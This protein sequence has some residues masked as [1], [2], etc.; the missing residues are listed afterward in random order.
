MA[1]NGHD[2]APLPAPFAEALTNCARENATITASING[3]ALAYLALALILARAETAVSSAR[4]ISGN[5][6]EGTGSSPGD[7][8]AFARCISDEREP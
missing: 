3:R 2:V 4:R 8:D 1:N 7:T 6:L 5:D